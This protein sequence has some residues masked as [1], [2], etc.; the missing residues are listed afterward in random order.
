MQTN[1]VLYRKNKKILFLNFF[2][3]C[4][5]LANQNTPFLSKFLFNVKLGTDVKACNFDIADFDR[6]F[7]SESQPF[8]FASNTH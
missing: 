6:Q 7:F 1:I 3:L 4:L 8:N 5:S 2:K